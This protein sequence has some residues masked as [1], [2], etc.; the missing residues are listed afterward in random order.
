MRNNRSVISLSVIAIV[1]LSSAAII[2]TNRA[3]GGSVYV[4][5]VSD[6]AGGAIVAWQKEGIYVQ[7]LD[8]S[9]RMLW[10]EGGIKVS[11]AV[12]PKDPYGPPVTR[13]TLIADG[14]GGAVLTWVDRAQWPDDRDD[15][16]YYDPKPFYSQR[17]S[18]NGDLLWK[19]TFV[20][21]GGAMLYG[22]DFPAVIA[23]GTGGAIFAWNNYK[24][25]YK[26]LHDDFF[27]VQKLS[28]DGARLWG[29]EGKT[30]V[31]SSPYRPLTEEEIAAGIKGT[32]GRSFPNYTG[33]HDIASA[34][35]GGVFVVWEEDYNSQGGNA[36]YAQRLNGDGNPVWN[37][38]LTVPGAPYVSG[39]L[40]SDG[41]GGAFFAGPSY[42]QH[43]GGN[44]E[45]LE[46]TGYFP[47]SVS[48]GTGGS[49]RFRVENDP[50]YV[51]P[52]A[53]PPYY[54]RNIVYVGRVDDG[55]KPVWPEKQVFASPDGSLLAPVDYASDGEGGTILLWQFKKDYTPYG[56]VYAQKADAEGN[57]GWGN[58]GIAVFN[59][60]G[61][62][63]DTAAVFSDGAG[64]FLVIA[65]AGEKR[66]GGDMVYVQRLSAEG[67]RLWGDGVRV[68][69]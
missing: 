62:Y 3:P 29:D 40:R 2:L 26:A 67:T 53:I 12:D 64:G 5:A 52:S 23:D 22:D 17:V 45:L 6:G 37:D 56:G 14:T 4:R 43:V 55:G 36:I 34:G 30:L 24:T 32:I 60:P 15:P 27:R 13:F 50:R 1:V 19:D 68:D 69:R 65:A 48:D 28:P 61:K 44:G 11:E 21:N 33:T 16:A 8:A 54:R 31:S 39:S 7:R 63:Q 51:A 10:K 18:A 46:K 35:D 59:A 57:I 41:S 38:R 25:Y 49:I 47:D 9:G 66:T 58:E 42:W 20:G